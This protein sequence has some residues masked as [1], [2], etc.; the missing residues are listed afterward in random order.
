[1]E[2]KYKLFIYKDSDIKHFVTE[3]AFTHPTEI[4]EMLNKYEGFWCRIID[5]STLGIVIEGTFD[6]DCLNE[7]YY[8]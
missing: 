2:L 6:D 4:K 1:M 7:I 5:L 3:K 8:R